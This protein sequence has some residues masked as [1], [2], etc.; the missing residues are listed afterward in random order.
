MGTWCTL[1]KEEENR[2]IHRTNQ[3]RDLCN[4][5]D[6]LVQD[7]QEAKAEIRRLKKQLSEAAGET[8]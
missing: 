8:D 1:A 2:Q 7:L 4:R 6:R 5:N 3:I